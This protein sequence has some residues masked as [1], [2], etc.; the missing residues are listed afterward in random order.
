MVRTYKGKRESKVSREKI[1]MAVEA[2]KNGAKRAAAARM[3]GISRTTLN[4]RL[5]RGKPSQHFQV[6][7]KHFICFVVDRHLT[8]CD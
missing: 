1:E 3:Y 6:G 8:D 5:K 7:L 2:V 4:S